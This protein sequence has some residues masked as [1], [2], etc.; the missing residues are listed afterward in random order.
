MVGC[1]LSVTRVIVYVLDRGSVSQE[2]KVVDTAKDRLYV[3]VD[4]QGL[5][6]LD[7]SDPSTPVKIGDLT[8]I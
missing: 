3:T 4:A 2:L 6:V 8:T 5:F 1:Q 7:V